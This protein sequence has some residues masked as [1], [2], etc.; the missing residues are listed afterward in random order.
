MVRTD[1]TL[2]GLGV[3]VEA[4]LERVDG[5]LFTATPRDELDELARTQRLK[6][7]AFA[8]SLAVGISVIYAGF[9]VASGAGSTRLVSARRTNLPASVRGN[10]STSSTRVGSL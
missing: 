7:E 8:L 5:M 6:D 2:E 9:V 10:E 3:L 1:G 4:E